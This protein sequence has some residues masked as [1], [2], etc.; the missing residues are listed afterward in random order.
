[1][2]TGTK[3]YKTRD[4]VLARERQARTPEVF[5]ESTRKWAPY[6]GL[7]TIHDASPITVDEAADLLPAGAD[8]GLLDDDTNADAKAPLAPAGT[9]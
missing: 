2:A 6:A 8:R 1:M 5:H 7:D 9:P 4:W 3:F